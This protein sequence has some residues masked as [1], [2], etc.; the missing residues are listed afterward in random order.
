MKYTLQFVLIIFIFAF[1]QVTCIR[2]QSIGTSN[3]AAIAYIRDG[4]EIRAI[5]PDGSDDHRIWS[6]PRADLAATMG[7]NGVAWSPD[8]KELAFSSAHEAV[9]SLYLSDLYTINP[10]GGGLRRVTNPPDVSDYAREPKGTVTV[11]VT[12]APAGILAAPATSFLVYVAGAAEPQQIGLPPGASRT[13]TF[14]DV[15]DLGNHPQPVV[16]MFGK[17]RWFIPG[18]DVV[19]GRTVN[20]GTLNISGRGLENFGAYGVAWTDDGAQVTYGLGNCGGLFTVP[21]RALAGSHQDKPA[22]PGNASANVCTWDWGPTSSTANEILI[23]GGMLDANIY[24]ARAGEASRGEKLVSAGATDLMLEVQWLPDA[25]G[26]LFALSTGSSANIY[27]YN[28]ATKQPRQLT[29]FDGE[30]VRS[31]SVSPDGQSIVFERA[32]QFRGGRSDLWTMRIDGRGQ[33]LLV[34][35]GNGPSWGK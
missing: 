16:A 19:A 6:V 10:D 31:F 5:N 27:V 26:F 9:Q 18:V 17:S 12:N 33:R 8:G 20:A 24:L 34:K 7:I 22:L 32:E 3:H 28:L 11:T 4:A 29:H 1:A 14:T 35:D 15:A 2:S 23:G 13:L 25:S 21:A 30:F